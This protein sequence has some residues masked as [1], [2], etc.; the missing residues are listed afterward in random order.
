MVISMS[1]PWRHPDT[2]VWCF[3]GRLPAD[4]QE[5]LTGQKLSLRV[6]GYDRT[7]TLGPI[8]GRYSSDLFMSQG[9]ASAFT[10]VGVHVGY[11]SIVFQIFE[12]LV[13]VGFQ[14]A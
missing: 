13:R 12:V 14:P 6:A 3:R 1:Q 2:G 10:A 9:G 11:I 4:L 5:R 8:A 7:L